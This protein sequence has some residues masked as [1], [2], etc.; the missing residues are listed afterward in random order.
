[1]FFLK[2]LEYTNGKDGHYLLSDVMK[3][4]KWDL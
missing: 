2:S 4:D 1:M 3:E